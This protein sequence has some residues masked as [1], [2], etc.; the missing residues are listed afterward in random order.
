M[1]Q[2]MLWF[3]SHVNLTTLEKLKQAIEYCKREKHFTPVSVT[4]HY[5]AF[6]HPCEL[7]E[8]ERQLGVK[9]EQS[10]MVLPHHYWLV[11][12]ESCP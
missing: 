6:L 7:I 5:S 1:T 3:N 9:I 12:E 4:L 8:A 10:N 11:G 2:Q